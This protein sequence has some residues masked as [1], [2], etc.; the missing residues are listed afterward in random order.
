MS[1]HNGTDIDEVIKQCS[2]TGEFIYDWKV[3][4]VAIKERISNILCEYDKER[5]PE[6]E[7]SNEYKLLISDLDKL[8]QTPF[9]IQR[10]CDLLNEPKRHYKY[11]CNKFIFSFHKMVNLD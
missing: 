11:N 9:T 1:E 5:V 10:I 7:N 6:F 4:K 3:F 2:L 8:N